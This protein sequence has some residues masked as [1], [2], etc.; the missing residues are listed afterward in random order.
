M[1]SNPS[2][3]MQTIRHQDWETPGSGYN[4]TRAMQD[5]SDLF[6]RPRNNRVTASNGS[7]DVNVNCNGSIQSTGVGTAAIT[8]QRYAELTVKAR[9][10]FHLNASMTLYVFVMRTTGA[11]PAN[12]AAPNAGDVAVSGDAFSG[13]QVTA[14]TDQAGNMSFLDTDLLQTTPYKY[15]FAVEGTNGDTATLKQN[16][17]LLVM[18][19]S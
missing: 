10:K 12:G 11:I 14:N 15:Y 6:D 18:E 19:R 3:L 9:A 1:S 13:G 17:Q 7:G 5:I 4:R 8:P 16:S 2:Q